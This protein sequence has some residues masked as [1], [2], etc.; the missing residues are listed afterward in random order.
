MLFFFLFLTVSCRS[1]LSSKLGKPHKL[2]GFKKVQEDFL[3][4]VTSRLTVAQVVSNVKNSSKVTFDFV[5][6]TFFAG[7]IASCGI[8]NN[9]AVDIAASMCIEPVMAT[10]LVGAFGTVIHDYSL[11]KAGIRNNVIVIVEC[12]VIG[13]G[14][15]MIAMNWSIEWSPPDEIWPT[16]EMRT[17]GLYR[18]LW[19]GALQ[20][21]AAG[22]AVALSL[23][24]NNYTALV[25]V[26]IASTFL[27]RSCFIFFSF[28]G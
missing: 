21:S 9:S 8:M 11:I 4:S 2:S 15:G 5:L 14:Y 23:L 12:I 10:V 26:A 27:V 24:N 17:R 28:N 25:G 6:Y 3:R 13:F 18:S 22:G 20:S 19:V 7:C 1:E 16:E